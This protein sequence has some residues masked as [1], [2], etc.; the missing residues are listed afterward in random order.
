MSL[1]TL[2]E[3]KCPCGEAFEAEVYQSVSAGEDPELKELI[4]GG[5]FNMVECPEC[6]N[7]IYAE[8][9]VLYHD[10]SQELLAFVYPIKMKDQKEHVA[11]DMKRTYDALRH[12]LPE[13]E[14]LDYIPFALFGMDEL[15]HI[16]TLEDEMAD[17]AEV[18]AYIC[19]ELG[20]K[21]K[22]VEKSAARK[23]GIPP[24]LPLKSTRG[25]LRENVLAG[26]EALL[27]KNDR[28]VHYQ[29]LLSRLQSDSNWTI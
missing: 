22:R 24:V 3:I 23:K 14:S 15:C 2:E 26:V 7:V 6:R 28:L 8:R 25:N 21:P 4:L 12:A 18:A 1:Q 9:F 10:R 19:K 20:L 5:E 17:E 11:V 13:G 16:L 29:A 27:Q